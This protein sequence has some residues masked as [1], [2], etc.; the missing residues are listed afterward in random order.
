MYKRQLFYD[1]KD[2]PFDL[3]T[4][5][6]F[7]QG[8]SGRYF[9]AGTD[10]S[11]KGHVTSYQTYYGDAQVFLDQNVFNKQY[12]KVFFMSHSMGGHIA[13]ALAKRNPSI[14]TGL[15]LSSP[16]IDIKTGKYTKTKAI[17]L[18]RTM[19]Y[20]GQG[21]KWADGQKPY[22]MDAD[23]STNEVTTSENRLSPLNVLKIYHAASRKF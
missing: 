16:M 21:T 19:V 5:D 1:L 14:V 6:H 3:Y 23:F 11:S 15:I 8:Y 18:S 10:S 17:W 22:K 9:K 20:L 13:L 7:G 12:K 2:L 4:F